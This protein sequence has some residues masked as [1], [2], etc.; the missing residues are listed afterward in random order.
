MSSM[1]TVIV[2][3]TQGLAV[4]SCQTGSSRILRIRNSQTNTTYANITPIRSGSGF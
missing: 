2:R 1:Y 3:S 4:Y